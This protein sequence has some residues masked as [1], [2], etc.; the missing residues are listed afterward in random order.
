MKLLFACLFFLGLSLNFAAAPR[1]EFYQVITSHP[2]DI[3][4]INPFIETAYQNGRLWI[5][6]VRD[7]AP[8]SVMKHLRKLSGGEKS[9]LPVNLFRGMK[10]RKNTPVSAQ[11]ALLNKDN[12]IKDVAELSAYESRYVGTPDNRKALDS[13]IERLKSFGYKVKEVCYTSDSC[14][15]VADKKGKSSEVIMVMAHID[16][17]GESFAGADDNGSGVAVLLE[18]AR[19]LKDYKN[20]KTIRFFITNGEELGLLGSTYYAKLLEANKELKKLSLVIN[21]D[22]VGYNQNGIV[23]LETDPA[24]QGMAEWYAGIAH[25]YTSLKTKI[26]LGAW[27][28]DHIPFLKRGVPSMLTIENWDTKTPCYHEACDTPDTLNYDYAT[29]IGKLNVAAVMSKDQDQ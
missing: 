9:Y 14:S 1:G 2:H 8:A 22:M 6:Y 20:N 10:M 12:I 7:D 5:V 26:T 4:E 17:V 21:M 19:V 28:S 27:G 23:E 11:I 29:E 13:S 18:M 24:F 15:V 16:S 3:F 25:R